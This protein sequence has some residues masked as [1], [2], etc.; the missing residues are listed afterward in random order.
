[1]LVCQIICWLILLV[2]TMVLANIGL[3]LLF[4]WSGL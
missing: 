2:V 3:K 4:E 1:M